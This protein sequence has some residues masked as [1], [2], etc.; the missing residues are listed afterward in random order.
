MAEPEAEPSSP[1]PDI[2]GEPE[3]VGPESEPENL[4]FGTND[5]DRVESWPEPEPEWD[6]AFNE[7]GAVWPL[8]VY[9]FGTCY[10]IAFIFAVLCVI[11]IVKSIKAGK[12]KLA[13]SL[14]VMVIIFNASRALSLFMEPYYAYN[15][16]P[17][18]TSRIIWSIG[19]PFLTSS[20]SLV[21]LVLLDTTKMEIGPP[22]FQKM[23]VILTITGIHVGIVL[24]SDFVVF[25]EAAAKAMLVICQLLFMIY[26][27]VLAIG[28][29]YVGV[30]IRQNSSAGQLHGKIEFLFNIFVKFINK[31]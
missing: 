19:V 14:L 8:H 23:S 13:F 12:G 22:R 29:L 31:K 28:Y 3:F 4:L 11:A 2:L 21:F 1:E 25:Y 6:A 17:F 15:N 9:F 27:M 16:I 5:E 20:F 7:W 10:A 24:V 18:L 30:K 26:G